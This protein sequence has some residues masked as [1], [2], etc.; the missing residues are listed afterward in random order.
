MSEILQIQGSGGLDMARPI[1][2]LYG[3]GGGGG[4][5]GGDCGR[6]LRSAWNKDAAVTPGFLAE[7]GNICGF[8]KQNKTAKHLDGPHQ[9]EALRSGEQAPL[10]VNTSDWLANE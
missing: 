4:E 6:G 7:R 5:G 10:T 8:K 1:S 3:L 9:W 2:T